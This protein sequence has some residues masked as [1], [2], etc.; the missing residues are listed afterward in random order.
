[1]AARPSPTIAELYDE[2][3]QPTRHYLSA[4]TRLALKDHLTRLVALE[5]H[6][7]TLRLILT[8]NTIEA[9]EREE[10]RQAVFLL[11]E[12]VNRVQEAVLAEDRTARP[13]VVCSAGTQSNKKGDSCSRW[14]LVGAVVFVGVAVLTRK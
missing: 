14:L 1:M 7:E 11:L 2:L 12:G 9:R 4:G 5:N 3:D 6:S 8:T 13:S 10:V